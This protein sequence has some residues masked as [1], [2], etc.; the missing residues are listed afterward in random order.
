MV[1]TQMRRFRGNTNGFGRWLCEVGKVQ[2]ELVRGES[3]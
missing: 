3:G 1:P 2:N